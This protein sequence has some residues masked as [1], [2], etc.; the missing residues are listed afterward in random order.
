MSI[1]PPFGLEPRA[2]LGAIVAEHALLVHVS[3]DGQVGAVHAVRDLGMVGILGGSATATCPHLQRVT[4]QNVLVWKK[5]SQ[6]LRVGKKR[7]LIFGW[8]GK[9]GAWLLSD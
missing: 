2:R 1:R 4:G 5:A 9:S 6:G 7:S 8:G 3:Q